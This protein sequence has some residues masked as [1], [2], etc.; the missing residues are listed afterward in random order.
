MIRA[1][2]LAHY[3]GLFL[4]VLAVGMLGL[5]G[6]TLWRGDPT[7]FKYSFL[8]TSVVGASLYVLFPPP[9]T[10]LS[11]REAF[12]LVSVVWISVS[13]F[14]GLPFYFSSHFATFTDAFFE[15]ASGFTTT[16]ATVLADVEVLPKALQFWRCFSHW[17]GGMGIVLLGIAIFPLLG[18]G[19]MELYRAEFPGAKSEKL[20]PRI[21]ETV[22]AL[23]KIYFALTVAQYVALR[24]AGMS[25]FESVCHTFSTIGTGG[26]S[27]RTS[28]IAAFNSPIIEYILIVF[29]LLAGLNFTLHYRLWVEWRPKGFFLDLEL[30][31][32]LLVLT[33][34]TGTIFLSLIWQSGYAP[35]LALRNALFQVASIMTTTGFITD[36]FENWKPLPQLI[37]LALMFI[38]GCTASTAGGLKASRI[39]LLSKV[40]GREFKRMVER[41]AVFAIRFGNQVIPESVIQNLLNLVYLSFLV[42]FVACLLLAAAGIDVLTSI[43]A[44]AATMFNVGPGLGQVGPSSHYGHLPALAK[45]VLTGCMLGGRLEFYIFLVILTPAFW[46]K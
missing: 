34:S 9:A 46:R 14:G 37:L 6:Y 19:G 28:S 11:L 15:A 26:F 2:T 8:I 21:I 36:N 23:W 39:L 13:A 16:G 5:L 12:L 35:S 3:L 45:W 29:M 20:K 38:G 18:L 42:N 27:T 30:R 25:P 31:F 43:S 10:E 44:V 41:R 1:T 7:P 40:V 4:L 32:Y 17:L 24:L 33:V 22:L